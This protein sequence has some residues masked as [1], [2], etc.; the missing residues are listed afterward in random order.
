MSTIAAALG[1]A[2]KK[3]NARQQKRYG[4]VDGRFPRTLARQRPR[5]R[6]RE[7]E[8]VYPGSLTPK[9]RLSRFLDFATSRRD[10]RQLLIA[11]GRVS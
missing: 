1:S 7:I 4:G 5:P 6:L 3:A 8:Y 2:E 11:Q 9:R 10:A